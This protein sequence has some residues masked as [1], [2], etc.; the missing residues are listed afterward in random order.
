MAAAIPIDSGWNT[1][2]PSAFRA[3]KAVEGEMGLFL[4][5]FLL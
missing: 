3:G 1:V 4:L 2:G 5:G